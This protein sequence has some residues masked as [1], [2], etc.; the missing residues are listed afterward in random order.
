MVVLKGVKLIFFGFAHM[1]ID[2]SYEKKII[3][4]FTL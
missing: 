2:N 3:T 4:L 1:M